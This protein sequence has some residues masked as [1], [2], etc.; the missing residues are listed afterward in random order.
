MT[1]VINAYGNRG[2]WNYRRIVREMEWRKQHPGK[3]GR[4]N[5]YLSSEDKR[6][7]RN[8]ARHGK[9]TEQ[10]RE[11]I[12]CPLAIATLHNKLRALNIRPDYMRREVTKPTFHHRP[13]K[14]SSR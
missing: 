13:D 9:S 10:I 4:H 8:M 1:H 14:Y 3:G 2:M 5:Y 6:I 11:A 12:A 7:A